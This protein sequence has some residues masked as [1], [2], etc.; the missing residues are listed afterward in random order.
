MV[1]CALYIVS[2]LGVGWRGI[3]F[4]LTF[5]AMIGMLGIYRICGN[6]RSCSSLVDL[7]RDFR[8]FKKITCLLIGILL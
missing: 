8:A 6:F 2:L 3:F 1:L 7:F 5:P 4:S